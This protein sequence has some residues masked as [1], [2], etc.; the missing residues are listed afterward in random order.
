MFH[1]FPVMFLH[2]IGHDD[3]IKPGG[4][5][6]APA[7]LNKLQIICGQLKNMTIKPIRLIRLINQKTKR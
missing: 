4:R 6:Q 3:T 5:R 2:Y 1:A 7:V